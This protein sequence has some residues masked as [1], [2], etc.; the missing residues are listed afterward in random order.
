MS[1][2]TLRAVMTFGLLMMLWV[3][4]F[5][6][7]SSL[8]GKVVD[9]KG[10]VLLGATIIIKGS[11]ISTATNQ[12]GEYKI[13]QVPLGK[14]TVTVNMI[15]YNSMDLPIQIVS[16]AN[17]L[18]F[19]LSSSTSDLEEVVVIGYGVAKKKTNYRFYL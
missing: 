9:N 10:E 4:A 18:N 7:N 6:Q 5:S 17:V 1:K 15:G 8:S 13:S 2:F 19:T 3:N 14:T 11:P 12:N 16:G